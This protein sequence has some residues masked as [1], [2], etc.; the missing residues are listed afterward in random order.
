VSKAYKG[1]ACVYCTTPNSAVAPDHVVARKFFLKEHRD[2]LPKVPV[3]VTCNTVKSELE[4]YAMSVM[5]FAGRHPD[6]S[7]NLLEL[8]PQRLAKNARLKSALQAGMARHAQTSSDRY[9]SSALTLPLDGEKIEKLF[10]LIAQGLCFWHWGI[11]LPKD[12]FDVQLG[13]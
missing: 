7:R 9:V 10:R 13:T 12:Q 3:C 1:K 2:N 6:S 4:L 8:V 5:P 11:L